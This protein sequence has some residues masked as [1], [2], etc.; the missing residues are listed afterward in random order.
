MMVLQQQQQH[1]WDATATTKTT[2][3]PQQS[4]NVE[5]SATKVCQENSQAANT[6]E[7]FKDNRYSSYLNKLGSLSRCALLNHLRRISISL[8]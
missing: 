6:C 7:F 8:I 1:L 4:P 2:T 5:S 3:S